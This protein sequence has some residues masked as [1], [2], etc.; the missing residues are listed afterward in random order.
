MR[1]DLPVVGVQKRRPIRRAIVGNLPF[2]G[3]IR[4]HHE[5]LG[6]GRLDQVL[7][8][9]RFVLGHFFFAFW[10][11][12]T[13]NDGFAVPGKERPAVVTLLVRQ[14]LYAAAIDI[15]AIDIEIAAA[16]RGKDDFSPIG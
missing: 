12:R 6:S 15:H 11:V 8:E 5:N 9:Q 13:I 14:S 7:L 1:N 3:S 4:S 16:H 10:V 2:V